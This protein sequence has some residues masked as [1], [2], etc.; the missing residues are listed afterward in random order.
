L[1]DIMPYKDP[2]KQK[3]WARIARR[4]TQGYKRGDRL[5]QFQEKYPSADLELLLPAEKE[6]IQRYYYQG[7]SLQAIADD[8]NCSREWIRKIIKMG[9]KKFSSMG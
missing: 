8:W 7:E 5:S 9:E 1:E 2:E 6:A 3:E 4:K